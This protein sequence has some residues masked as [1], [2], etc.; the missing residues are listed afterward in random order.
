[1]VVTVVL[2]LLPGPLESGEIVGHAQLVATGETVPVRSVS[3]L[4][5]LARTAVA[6]DGSGGRGRDPDP[7]SVRSVSEADI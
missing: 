1:M 4:V 7:T 6:S 5:G 2:R 3:D